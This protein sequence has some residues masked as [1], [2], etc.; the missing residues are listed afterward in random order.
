MK[1]KPLA[2][3][4]HLT[5]PVD[6]KILLSYKKINQISEYKNLQRNIVNQQFHREHVLPIL[7]KIVKF[8]LGKRIFFY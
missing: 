2:S 1:P 7:V 8:C 5:V 6:I 4:N 3:L